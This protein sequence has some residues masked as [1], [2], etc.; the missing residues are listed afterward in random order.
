MKLVESFKCPIAIESLDFTKK[1]AKIS[2][3]RKVY[4]KM[5]ILL[6]TEMFRETLESRCKRFG[7]E[8]I[9]VN[10][11]FMGMMN[12]MTKYGFNS[13]TAAALVIGCRGLA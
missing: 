7:V 9:K 11:A 3:S 12:Y 8:L 13:S 5:L 2:E 6:S 4:N 10:P 1:K